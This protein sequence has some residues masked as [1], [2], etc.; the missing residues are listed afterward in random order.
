MRTPVKA[1]VE[2]ATLA[3]PGDG[4]IELAVTQSGSAIEVFVRAVSGARASVFL[5]GEQAWTL[6]RKLRFAR[7]HAAHRRSKP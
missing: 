7:L 4:R 6:E 1:L 5:S 2:V 3:L